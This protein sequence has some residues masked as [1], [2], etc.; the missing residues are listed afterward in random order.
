MVSVAALAQ[1]RDFRAQSVVLDDGRGHNDTLIAPVN[2]TQSG[3]YTFPLTA[4]AYVYRGANNGDLLHWDSSS[5]QNPQGAWVPVSVSSLGLVSGTGVSGRVAYWNGTN[6]VTS[7]GNFMYNASA[8]SFTV[9]VQ[10]FTFGNYS[11]A[12][13]STDTA[14]FGGFAIGNQTHAMQ[15]G[16][17][18]IGY[19]TTASGIA[20]TAMG[21]AT[22]ASGIGSVAMGNN[23][24]AGGFSSLATGSYTIASGDESTTIGVF[25]TA[26][27]TYTTVIGTSSSASSIGAI[28]IGTR[29]TASGA[30]SVAIGGYANTNGMF[31]AV[32]IGDGTLP[33]APAPAAH[34][35]TV[36]ATGGTTIYS[37]M[38][39]PAGVSLSPGGS[40]WNA[41]SDR[42][43]KENFRSID[44][45]KLLATLN[46]VPVTTWSYKSESPA[47]R[48]MGPM[49]QDMYAAFG[50]GTS[51]TMINSVDIDGLNLAGIEAL[52]KRTDNLQKE[53][54]ELRA[55]VNELK[56]IVQTLAEEKRAGVRNAPGLAAK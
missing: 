42:N 9:G 19:L 10:S 7:D 56:A 36:L 41:V 17:T 46:D 16:A 20:S 31:S 5:V 13:G 43:K 11:I 26:S 3:S 15:L 34:T 51:D 45:E 6:S 18:A 50:L 25:D 40:G 23:T 30:N 39:P 1:T 24:K 4:S 28:S 8:H 2:M 54:D 12:M 21:Q 35:F 44:G 33:Q 29:N 48:H 53:N 49:A 38:S 14:Y 22:T 55:E 32:V 37:S 27:A 52:V 47:I